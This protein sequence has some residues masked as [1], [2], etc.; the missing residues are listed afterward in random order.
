MSVETRLRMLEQS[1]ARVKHFQSVDLSKLSNKE[2]KEYI[3]EL[4]SHKITTGRY[5]GKRIRDLSD[6]QLKEYEQE[7]L[8][9]QRMGL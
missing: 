9:M 2:L 5:R 8:A 7:L 4:E 3:E 1:K 6:Q